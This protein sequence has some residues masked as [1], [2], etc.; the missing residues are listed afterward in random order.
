MPTVI[1][2]G[3]SAEADV[4]ASG[5]EATSDGSDFTLHMPESQFSVALSL[6]GKHNVLNACAAAAIARS[7]GISDKQI[8]QGLEAVQPFHGRLQPVRSASGAVLFDDSYNANPVSVQAA[9]EFLATQ[10]GVSWLVLGDMAELGGDGELLHA[11]TGWVSQGSRRETPA[12]HRT[13]VEKC[14]RGVWR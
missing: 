7:L 3:L 1:S 6:P 4:R 10:N 14:G 12:R 5:I 13:V 11:H 8:K 9:A 2:F